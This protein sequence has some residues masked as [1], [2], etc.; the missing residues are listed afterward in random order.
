VNG[1]CSLNTLFL[2]L[3]LNK[4]VKTQK[5][6]KKGKK[7]YEVTI[8]YWDSEEDEFA[9]QTEHILE[10][11]LDADLMNNLI[12]YYNWLYGDDNYDILE[13]VDEIEIWSWKEFRQGRWRGFY[14]MYGDGE[15]LHV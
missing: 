12:S 5:L 10:N 6:W 1:K 14:T 3:F 4:M 8:Q 9:Y 7:V 11:E 2:L 15:E 13:E